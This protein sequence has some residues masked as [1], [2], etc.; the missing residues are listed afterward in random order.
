MKKI[1]KIMAMLLAMVMVLGMTVTASAAETAVAPSEEIPAK[2]SITINHLT[3]N[4]NTT[5]ELYQV[6]KHNAGKSCWEASDWVKN[7][8]EETKKT[9]VSF[10]PD[11]AGNATIDW[12]NLYN[13]VTKDNTVVPIATKPNIND[14][15]VSFGDLEAGSYL[16]VAFGDNTTYNV[17]GVSTYEYDANS[18]L[19]V[20]LAAKISAKGEGYKVTKTL[21]GK[22]T[23][24]H[25]GQ[26]LTFN[27]DSV[28]PSFPDKETDRKVSITDK[29]TGQYVEDVKVYVGEVNTALKEGEDYT[30]SFGTDLTTELP[31]KVDEKV[32]VNFTE[33]F[34]G[35]DNDHAAQAIK[36]VVTTVVYDVTNISNSAYGSHDSTPDDSNVETSTGSITINKVDENNRVLTGAKF[37][38]R[39]HGEVHTEGEPNEEKLQFVKVGDG[40]YELATKEDRD[41]RFSDLEV[42]STTG[43]LTVNGLGEGTYHITEEIAPNG[44]SVVDVNDVTLALDDKDTPDVDEANVTLP[45]KNTKLSA[46][47]ETGGIGTTIFTIGGCAIMV[48]AAGLFFASRRKAN[49]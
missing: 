1:K 7:L 37:S 44:Y 36:V 5:V 29:P 27:I 3:P 41:E 31:A 42:N 13:F 8:E 11:E 28:F 20:P 21:N 12:D 43:T 47:P 25:R 17:M 9:F 6:V 14:T 39:L 33:A 15:S 10:N 38:F 30:L 19:L 18:N 48:A 16:V 26:T 34:I 46:L 49:K 22:E 23:L 4:D 24:V 40:V 45:V 35:K 2:A 32:T